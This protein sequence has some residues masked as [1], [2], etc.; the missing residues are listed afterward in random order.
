MDRRIGA[1]LY[2]VRDFTKTIE[3]FDE[4]CRK[5]NEIGYK[6]VQISGTPLKADE[7][8]SVLNK[9]A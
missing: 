8:K 5:I 2:T 6:I 9:Y 3:D 4:T 7:M 1:Q